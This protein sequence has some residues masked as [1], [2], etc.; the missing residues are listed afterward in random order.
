MSLSNRLIAP[1]FFPSDFEVPRLIGLTGTKDQI[2]AVTKSYRVYYSA[3]PAD[4]D[5]DYIVSSCSV[6]H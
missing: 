1:K 2:Q 3:G 6:V 5:N 4:E